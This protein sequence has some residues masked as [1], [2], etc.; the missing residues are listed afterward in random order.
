MVGYLT[1]D[2]GSLSTV[3]SNWPL[4]VLEHGSPSRSRSGKAFQLF[5][6]L[7]LLEEKK[8]EREREIERER[9]RLKPSLDDAGM[10]SPAVSSGKQTLAP[11]SFDVVQG[12]VVCEPSP[13]G[14]QTPGLT[15]NPEVQENQDGG[16]T[17]LRGCVCVCVCERGGVV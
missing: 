1:G 16:Q 15:F 13:R 7:F 9:E 8:R 3:E 11:V 17:G 12:T 2:L 5:H 10:A 14:V 4:N 6:V